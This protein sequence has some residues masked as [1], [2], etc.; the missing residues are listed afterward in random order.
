MLFNMFYRFPTFTDEYNPALPHIYV[1][2]SQKLIPLHLF[3][4]KFRK[5]LLY[6]LFKHVFLWYNI[7]ECSENSFS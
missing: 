7:M 3:F 4:M 5:N 2:L 6:P 1:S